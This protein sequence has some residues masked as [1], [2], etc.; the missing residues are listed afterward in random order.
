MASY[1]LAAAGSLVSIILGVIKK[2]KLNYV[3]IFFLI[4]AIVLNLV[5]QIISLNEYY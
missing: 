2:N 4:V 3:S 1:V 5:G